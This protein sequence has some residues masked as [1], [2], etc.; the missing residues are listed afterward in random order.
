MS[1][2]NP[3]VTRRAFLR[4]TAA[5]AAAPYV[6]P[7]S[8]FGRD[9]KVPPSERIIVGGIGIG[10][11]GSHDLRWMLPE[12]DVQFVAACDP[13]KSR[14]ERVKN[15][16]DTRYGHKSVIN[17]V[18]AIKTEDLSDEGLML[19]FQRVV[20]AGGEVQP[21]AFVHADRLAVRTRESHH[22]GIAGVH[23]PGGDFDFSRMRGRMAHKDNQQCQKNS[24]HELLV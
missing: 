20:A 15:I 5:L 16:V 14:R 2:K 3:K 24:Q 8:V 1:K 7:A 23:P 17:S 10:N 4:G 12:A 9:G 18:G 19:L 6:V 21:P 11:R 13:N 22:E